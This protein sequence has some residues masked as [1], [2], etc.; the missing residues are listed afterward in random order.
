MRLI[1]ADKLKRY[2][3]G[4]RIVNGVA[5]TQHVFSAKAIDEMIDDQPTVSDW[6]GYRGIEDLNLTLRSYKFLRRIGYTQIGDLRYITKEDLF[7]FSGCGKKTA[8]EIID[9]VERIK[10]LL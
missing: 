7:K 4:V 9:R 3:Q 6:L 8:E 5:E 10:P 1:D 2:I